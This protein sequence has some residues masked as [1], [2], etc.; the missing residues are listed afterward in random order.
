MAR[1]LDD[2]LLGAQQ[3]ALNRRHAEWKTEMQALFADV[4]GP[5]AA[6]TGVV[7]PEEGRVPP[8]CQAQADQLGLEPR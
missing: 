7:A 1:H 6:S 4:M 5:V 8:S 3:D 2:E